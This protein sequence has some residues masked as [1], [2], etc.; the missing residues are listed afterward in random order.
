MKGDEY[1]VSEKFVN[2]NE[3]LNELLEILH[4]KDLGLFSNSKN[5]GFNRIYESYCN[6]KV[7]QL[8]EIA[9][10]YNTQNYFND[11]RIEWEQSINRESLEARNWALL[12]KLENLMNSKI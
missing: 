6:C 1:F 7:F 11:L 4:S 2:Y 3:A 5:K 8:S 10:Y 12:E 9:I